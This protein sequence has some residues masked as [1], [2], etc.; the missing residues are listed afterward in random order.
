MSPPAAV[1]D[2]PLDIWTL[3][4]A[5]VEIPVPYLCNCRH[6]PNRNLIPVHEPGTGVNGTVMRTRVPGTGYQGTHTGTRVPG[7]N[8]MQT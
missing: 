6:L 5:S 4:E 7:Y 2:D 8:C 3:P 1:P